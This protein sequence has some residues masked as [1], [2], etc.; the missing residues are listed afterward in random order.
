[1]DRL[2]GKS[3]SVSYDIGNH[4]L[5]G[6]FFSGTLRETPH[7]AAHGTHSSVIPFYEAFPTGSI[8]ESEQR[9]EEM[10]TALKAVAFSLYTFALFLDIFLHY[11]NQGEVL[12][13]AKLV[14]SQ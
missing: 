4:W 10:S 8:P 3:N 2:F 6:H 11:D 9:L 12:M 5:I 13:A 7:L 1:M 14:S